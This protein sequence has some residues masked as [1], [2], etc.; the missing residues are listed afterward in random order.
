PFVELCKGSLNTFLNA[1]TWP[2]KTSYPVASRNTADFKNLMS[3]YM[4]AAFC[5]NIYKTENILKQEGWHY[6]L[7]SEEGELQIN[8]V[9]YN[10]MRGAFSNPDTVL[11]NLL[12]EKLYPGTTYE[13]V[14]GG[15]PEHIPELTYE[16]FLNFHRRYYH[17]S[18]AYIFLYGDM[19]FTERLNWLDEAYLSAYDAIDPKTDVGMTEPFDQV[20]EIRSVYNVASG[21]EEHNAMF[22]YA[23]A[24]GGL[25]DPIEAKA[26]EVLS[27]A[28]LNAPGAPLK[29]AL[30]ES[31]IGADVY[32]GYE[33]D[34]RQPNFN[35][36]M[37][38]A[39]PARFQE[40]QDI[41]AGVLQKTLQDGIPKKTLLAGINNIE[42]S[43]READYGR[44]PKGLVYNF[45]I[46]D[47]WLHDEEQALI[48]IKYNDTFRRLKE[49]VNTDYYERLAK[50]RILDN[51]FGVVIL[52]EPKAGL[53]EENAKKTAEK[54]AAYKAS[55]SKEEIQKLIEDTKALKAYQSAG[56]TKEALESIPLLKLSEVD[57]EP[58][59]LKNEE[60]SV[61]EIPLIFHAIPTSGIG[62]LEARFDLKGLTEEELP[63]AG[64]LRELYTQ[65]DTEEHNYQELGDEI[66][67]ETGGIGASTNAYSKAPDYQNCFADFGVTA[68]YLYDHTE[69]AVRLVK[70]VFGHSVFTDTARIKEIIDG[71]VSSGQ[72][73]MVSAGHS[74]AVK[75]LI[76]HLTATDQTEDQLSGLSFFRFLSKLKAQY[77]TEKGALNEKLKAVEKKIF[78]KKNLIL[79]FT[80][81]EEGYDLLMKALPTW[82]ND[83]QN[84]EV[85]AAIRPFEA[86]KKNEALKT[87]SLVQYNA[88]GG[89][90]RKHG[91]VYTGAFRVF[92]TLMRYEYLWMNIRVKGGAY[93]CMTRIQRAGEMAFVS[94]RDPHLKQTLEIY[95]GIAGY[96]EG[97][98][99][100][101]RELTKYILGT[102][103]EDDTPMQPSGEG[104]FAFAA[105]LAGMTDEMRKKERKQILNCTVEDL[106][107]IA[108]PVRAVIDEN[109][110]VT[111]GSEAK[112]EE[113][114]D[115][116]DT[117]ENLQGDPA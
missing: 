70:E 64:L 1:L 94:Y 102:I 85:P 92:N 16:E 101:E 6:E 104:T 63:Y 48:H 23:K 69:G 72:E 49:L 38:G 78:S 83:I 22:Q 53:A 29:K 108:G 62:Y 19:D 44:F 47:T 42:F 45:M 50:E 2:D 10:E 4:D 106:R 95:R 110:Y 93:G 74:T 82:L 9:V 31:G 27:Y 89:D 51:T 98:E 39:D 25:F 115:L 12:T 3:V 77:E 15:D 91:Y 46:M 21:E 14:S 86:E 76:S 8:G 66:S 40:F 96:L 13:V 88:M 17:P 109:R 75:R 57:P 43:L 30:L 71:L 5:P 97:L 33:G 79:S 41:I 24:M 73:A 67:F 80:G 87:S 55:L 54:L 61:G 105:Y 114:K 26:M 34:Y 37:K 7:E 117:V 11:R 32:G 113:S 35:I 99:L 111:L 20:K 28:L 107:A 84:P 52:M 36:V 65:V 58:A 81:D 56:E 59:P 116:F 90:F 100:D 18:N 60:R 68:R 103:G 112:I